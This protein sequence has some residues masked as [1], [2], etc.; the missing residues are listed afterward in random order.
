MDEKLCAI[1]YKI[2]KAIE[3][4]PPNERLGCSNEKYQI[5]GKK[6]EAPLA[7]I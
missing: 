1:N 7:D 4:E 5:N 6:T 2:F 3:G